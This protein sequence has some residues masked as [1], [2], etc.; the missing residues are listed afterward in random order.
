MVKES[1][2]G[3]IWVNQGQT[4]T[5]RDKQGQ[6]GQMGTNKDVE[7]GTNMDKHLQMRTNM[8]NRVEHGQTNGVVQLE[9]RRS[10]A[11]N[12]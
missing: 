1:Q 11:K 5:N 4:G 6:M 7:M 10:L 12:K 2:S 8:D 3:L 9:H